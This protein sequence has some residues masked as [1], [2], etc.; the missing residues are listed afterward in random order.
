MSHVAWNNLTMTD[1]NKIEN[2]KRKLATVIIMS[3]SL[4]LLYIYYII[5]YT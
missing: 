1:N 4:I 3:F 5:L 2:I